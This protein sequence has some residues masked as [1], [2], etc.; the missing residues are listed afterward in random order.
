MS[1]GY[2][3]LTECLVDNM[4]Y[5]GKHKGLPDGKYIGTGKKFLEHVKQHGR[6]NFTHAVLAWAET[7]AELRRLEEFYL[8]IVDARNNSMF[9]NMTNKSAGVHQQSEETKAKIS[10]ASK[11]QWADPAYKARCIIIRRELWGKDNPKRHQQ[12]SKVMS[13]IMTAIWNDPDK[14]V[15]MLTKIRRNPPA[16]SFTASQK[17]LLRAARLGALQRIVKGQDSFTG[18][19]RDA[20]DHFGIHRHKLSEMIKNGSLEASKVTADQLLALWQIELDQM[21]NI[22]LTSSKN[23]HF[24]I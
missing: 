9:L 14:R 4:L 12:Q 21:G 15:K 11:T 1:Y 19:L 16:P 13:N 2:V 5:I 20:Q 3:Y 8:E 17:R 7:A 23:N 18:S 6:Q 22:G 10:Q 24:V